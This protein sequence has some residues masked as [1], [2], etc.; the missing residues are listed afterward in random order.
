MSGPREPAPSVLSGDGLL[1]GHSVLG[2]PSGP[3]A[4]SKKAKEHAFLLAAGEEPE[5]VP[6]DFEQLNLKE[7]F[8]FKG[9]IPQTIGYLT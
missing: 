8:V 7:F 2:L 4:A 5:E 1:H 3:H 9:V 6:Q